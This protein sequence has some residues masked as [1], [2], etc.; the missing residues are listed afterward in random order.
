M[1]ILSRST[2]IWDGFS[3][4]SFAVS[5]CF[6]CWAFSFAASY[7]PGFEITIHPLQ[8]T[9]YSNSVLMM[10]SAFLPALYCF[11]TYPECRSSLRQ[12]N[13]SWKLYAAALVVG[14]CLPTTA[15]LDAHN[16]TFPWGRSA[17]TLLAAALA[18]NLIL[19]PLWEEI[20][21]RGCFLNKIRSFVSTPNAILLT[22]IGWTLWHG[23]YTAFYYSRGYSIRSLILFVLVVFSTGILLGSLFELGHGSIWPA[24]LGHS[25]FDAASVTYYSQYNRTSGSY[26]TELI[27][28]AIAAGFF[29]VA[30]NRKS[31]LS[32]RLRTVDKGEPSD[33][34]SHGGRLPMKTWLRLI[35]VLMTVGGGSIG[36]TLAHRLFDGPIKGGSLGVVI[37]IILM[38]MYAFVVAAGLLL[39]YDSRRIGPVLV[40]F[41][42]Q[43]PWISCPAFEYHFAAGL[44]AVIT[45]G[46]IRATQ[47]LLSIFELRGPLGT[48]FL[49]SLGTSSR[50]GPWRIGINLV[51]AILFVLSWLSV[52]RSS[53]K[54]EL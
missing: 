24:V 7:G 50:D 18:K 2:R 21:W 47:S 34:Q 51:A 14:A 30:A 32:I 42:L 11:I 27:F 15:Y 36:F 5:V 48:A 23:G 43:I 13:A 26:G 8:F 25:A 3:A 6:V 9:I 46:P 35:V 1:P 38:A 16:L 20:V 49:V 31:R 17:A 4:F 54:L 44:N 28:V 10:A 52:R 39:V 53:K 12:V 37:A 22:S 19:A 29:F 33:H 45:L 40:A 41:A